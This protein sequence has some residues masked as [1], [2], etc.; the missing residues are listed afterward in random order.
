MTIMTIYWA[1]NFPRTVLYTY[2]NTVSLHNPPHEEDN[3]TVYEIT[4]RGISKQ[5]KSE[6]CSTSERIEIFKILKFLLEYSWFAM[7]C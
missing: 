1:Y 3:I 6:F 7:L 2:F 4:Y 5:Q